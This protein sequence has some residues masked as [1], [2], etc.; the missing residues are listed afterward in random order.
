MSNDEVFFKWSPQFSVNIKIIDVQHREL[1]NIL[2]RLCSEVT[3]REGNKAIAEIL[4]ALMSYTQT[5]FVLEESLMR[6]AKF[7]DYEEHKLEHKKLI[8]QFDQLC[9]RHLLEETPIYFEILSFLKTWLK[10]HL[11][12]E[13]KK[14]RTALQQ[15]EFSV[16]AWEEE[17]SAE[18]A[19]M[20]N[21]KRQW[22]Q[23]WKVA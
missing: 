22:W 5:H 13:V 23:F 14:Y 11:L 10:G 16:S 17:V 18:F 4:D 12:D 7:E 1:V 2:N 15:S 3:K 8:E 19:F 20:S 21:A 9:K 6:Q